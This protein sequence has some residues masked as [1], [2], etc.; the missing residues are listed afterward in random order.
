MAGLTR[1]AVL[2]IAPILVA[3]APVQPSVLVDK[4]GWTIQRELLQHRQDPGKRVE[5]FWA[6]PIGSGPWPAVLLIH[7]HQEQIRNGGE[8]YVLTGRLGVLASRGYVTAA[9][10]QPGYGNSDGP[11][12]FCG[13]FTQDAAQTALAFL[14]ARPFVIPSKAALFGY[15]RGA[16]VA[17]MGAAR[18][19]QLAAGGLGAGAGGCFL[20]YP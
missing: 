5:V 10:S 14:R 1:R 16:I 19:P 12:D 4:S 6:K 9:L 20:R 3:C 7:G 8:A 17:S 2:L 15:S 13:P 11:A 18:A